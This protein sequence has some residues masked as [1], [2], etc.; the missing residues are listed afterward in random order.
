[1]CQLDSIGWTSGACK[2]STHSQDKTTANELT[3][4]I[5]CRLDSRADNNYKTANEYCFSATITISKEAAKRKCSD[6][7]EIVDNEYQTC[8]RTCTGEA[9]GLLVLGH[10]VD[11]THQRADAVSIWDTVGKR[12]VPVET[13]HSA[14]EIADTHLAQ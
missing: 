1:M 6:L 3:S 7:S 14:D 9:K 12:L 10:S 4:C 11:A 5:R 2:G 8:A 13:I